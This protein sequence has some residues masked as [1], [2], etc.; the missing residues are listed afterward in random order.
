MQSDNSEM[1]FAMLKAAG[2]ILGTVP[3]FAGVSQGIKDCVLGICQSAELKTDLSLT[4][5]PMVFVSAST[6]FSLIIFFFFRNKEITD[7][8]SGFIF[9]T[10]TSLS[11]FGGYF[12]STAIGKIVK[13]AC[14]VVTQQKKFFISYVLMMIFAELIVIF[15]LIMTIVYSLTLS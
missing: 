9:L 11:G 3:M 4:I 8:S 6:I 12:A 5:V 7:Y 10:A 14:F 13:F 1:H 2:L 15:A